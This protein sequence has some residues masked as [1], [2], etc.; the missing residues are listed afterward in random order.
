MEDDRGFISE[1]HAVDLV[2]NPIAETQASLSIEEAVW[3][4]IARSVEFTCSLCKNLTRS[5]AILR[6]LAR[7]YITERPASQ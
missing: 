6:E 7:I 1:Q 3:G 5:A 4:K 2:R